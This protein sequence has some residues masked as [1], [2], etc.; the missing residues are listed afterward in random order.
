M[1]QLHHSEL[2][3]CVANLK[4]QTIEVSTF[5][6]KTLRMI[7][8]FVCSIFEPLSSRQQF[9]FIAMNLISRDLRN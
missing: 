2:F 5:P 3:L 4:L 1:Y 8:K 6:K 9:V 7:S